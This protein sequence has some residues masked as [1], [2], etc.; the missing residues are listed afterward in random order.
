MHRFPEMLLASQFADSGAQPE[1]AAGM[2]CDQAKTLAPSQFH[3]HIGLTSH[4]MADT[5]RALFGRR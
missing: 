3:A 2:T 1:Q 4:G 5:Y